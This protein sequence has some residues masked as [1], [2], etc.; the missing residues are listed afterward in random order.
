MKLF[1]LIIL[2]FLL[3]SY[4]TKKCFKDYGCENIS[5]QEILCIG[6]ENLSKN[7]PC[8]NNT[9]VIRMIT[10][11]INNKNFKILPNH[12]FQNIMLK[13]L[14]LISNQI[15][16]ISEFTFQNLNETELIQLSQNKIKE[17]K[18]ELFLMMKDSLK[19]L[20]MNENNL[21]TIFYNET[22]IFKK[23]EIF[24]FAHNKLKL[25]PKNL[26]SKIGQSL[27]TLDLYNN[28]IVTL[29]GT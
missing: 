17:I 6:K 21:Q 27:V 12:L 14:N 3:K 19:Y 4:I 24:N 8:M 1:Y 10:L 16:V 13:R 29:D 28:Q 9:E 11:K 20:I 2:L 7:P 15:E 18:L 22:V 23:L 25:L 26:L 5:S